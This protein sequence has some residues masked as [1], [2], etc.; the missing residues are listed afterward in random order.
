MT[1]VKIV[2]VALL[3]F[4]GSFLVAVRQTK[5]GCDSQCRTRWTFIQLGA[6]GWCVVF[7]KSTCRYCTAATTMCDNTNPVDG[8]VCKDSG[9]ANTYWMVTGCVA[10]CLVP[11]G[12]TICEATGMATGNPIATT[13]YYWCD[14]PVPPGGPGGP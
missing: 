11:A 7:M 8:M 6:N 1:R 12:T 5:A 14:V 10:A 9:N 4:A 2:L 13:N 3:V